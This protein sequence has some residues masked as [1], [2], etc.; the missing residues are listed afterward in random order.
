MEEKKHHHHFHTLLSFLLNNPVRRHFDK[1]PEKIIRMLGIND[2]NVVLDFGC[3]PGF[4]AVPFARAAKKVVAVDIQE[5][6][7]KKAER[8][9]EKNGVKD[10]I[11]FVQ[12]DGEEIPE[13]QGALCDFVF[14]SLVYHEIDD[15]S[16]ERV[17]LELGRMLKPG[18]KLAIM[19]YTR[20]PLVGPLSVNPDEVK[21]ELARAGFPGAE[22]IKASK[23]VGLII[24]AKGTV[25]NVDVE[26]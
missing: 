13:L 7:L 20:K 9:A 1:K 10:K 12:T 16:K 21:K 4:Y 15:S 26:R 25:N 18:G 11:Q 23:N 19:E 14:L 22:V 3:G 8:Y 24:A 5:K 6:M 2:A 17:L